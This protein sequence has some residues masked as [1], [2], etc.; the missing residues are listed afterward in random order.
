MTQQGI[1]W[2]TRQCSVSYLPWDLGFL[3]DERSPL[4]FPPSLDKILYWSKCWL[5]WFQRRPHSA[6]WETNKNYTGRR[7]NACGV[8][9]CLTHSKR[10]DTLIVF[11]VVQL[12]PCPFWSCLDEV[13][14]SGAS[15]RQWSTVARAV[16]LDVDCSF[17]WC[18]SVIN[19]GPTGRIQQGSIP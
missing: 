17:F 19:R 7:W 15:L 2:R 4:C 16:S 3:S 1:F 12:L 18:S 5:L 8:R 13:C 10:R 6:K 9:I 11:V 14:F